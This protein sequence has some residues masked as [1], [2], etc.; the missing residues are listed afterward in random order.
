MLFLPKVDVLRREAADS[1]RARK[2]AY[3]PILDPTIIEVNSN[4]YHAFQNFYRGLY[5][6][7][8][9]LYRPRAES[10]SLQALSYRNSKVLMPSN[11]PIR[12]WRLVKE[13]SAN[14]ETTFA[15]SR[16]GCRANTFG[17][18]QF[19]HDRNIE[20]MPCPASGGRFADDCAQVGGESIQQVRLNGRRSS[21]PSFEPQVFRELSYICGDCGH[22][23]C[24]IFCLT[25]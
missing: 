4:G 18:S 17:S 25:P 16:L 12:N 3:R 6:R 23:R 11:L 22:Y 7:Y 15:E 19:L 20:E 13:D 9:L 5:V 10:M 8:A 21:S 2:D 24:V 1:M 14:C